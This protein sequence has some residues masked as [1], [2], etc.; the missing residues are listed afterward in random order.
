[1]FPEHDPSSR[2]V[3]KEKGMKYLHGANTSTYSFSFGFPPNSPP[4]PSPSLS[5]PPSLSHPLSPAL[6]QP[7]SQKLPCCSTRPNFCRLEQ[8]QQERI[9]NTN[10]QLWIYLY[11]RD[12]VRLQPVHH[13]L[14]AQTTCGWAMLICYSLLASCLPLTASNFLLFVPMH[15][16]KK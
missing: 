15:D 4:S 7:V 2:D 5:P 8:Q 6:A 10:Q 11:R 12:R 16:G 9:C 14:T 3:H 13:W 1:M